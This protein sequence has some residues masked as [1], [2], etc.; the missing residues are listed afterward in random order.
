MESAFPEIAEGCLRAFICAKTMYPVARQMAD[1][2]ASARMT[3]VRAFWARSA[4]TCDMPSKVPRLRDFEKHFH[5]SNGAQG[6][7]SLTQSAY[8]AVLA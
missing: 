7:S 2:T 8:S 1:V 3:K 4:G 5:C 6:P